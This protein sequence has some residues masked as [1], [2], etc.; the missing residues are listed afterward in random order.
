[1][2]SLA[3][4]E[5]GAGNVQILMEFGAACGSNAMVWPKNLGSIFDENRL[6]RLLAGMLHF[7]LTMG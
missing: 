4:H 2:D 7:H 1:M 5:P 6:V 3:Q